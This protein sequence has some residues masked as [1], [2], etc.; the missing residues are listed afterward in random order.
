MIERIPRFR[1]KK[2]STSET[3]VIIGETGP[4]LIR[5]KKVKNTVFN[6]PQTGPWSP[7]GGL[8]SVVKQ[9]RPI[10]DGPACLKDACMGTARAQTDTCQRFHQSTPPTSKLRTL[11]LTF[12]A[13]ARAW[14]PRAPMRLAVDGGWVWNGSRG[15]QAAKIDPS[16]RQDWLIFSTHP[17]RPTKS[18][19][20]QIIKGVQSEAVRHQ[21]RPLRSRA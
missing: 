4:S 1:Q 8:F 13:S 18:W 10:W 17:P 15:W 16:A 19:V 11:E 5:Q 9:S 3:R 12:R 20:R 6:Q 14:A 2:G 21:R 7:E